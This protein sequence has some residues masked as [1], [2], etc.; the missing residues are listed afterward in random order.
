MLLVF[1][2][3]VA[4]S[5]VL[6]KMLGFG[7]AVAVLLDALI[8]RVALVPAFMALVGKWNWWPNIVEP[9]VAAVADAPEPVGTAR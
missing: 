4:A 5:L 6:T 3:F 1:G 7:L 9:K 8:I 2:S